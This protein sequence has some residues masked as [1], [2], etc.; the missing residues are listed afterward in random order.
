MAAVDPEA[1]R[2]QLTAAPKAVESDAAP[3]I[4]VTDDGDGVVRIDVADTAV[5]RPGKPD[6][7]DD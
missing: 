6:R 5:V 7:D 2:E 1:R 3:R 4:E